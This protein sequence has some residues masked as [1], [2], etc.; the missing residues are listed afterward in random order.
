[1]LSFSAASPAAEGRFQHPNLTP[2]VL[3]LEK[4][5]EQKNFPSKPPSS[6]NP[7]SH[8]QGAEG[9]LYLFFSILGSLRFLLTLPRNRT[10]VPH[11]SSAT[12]GRYVGE[13]SCLVPWVPS[14]LHG[15]ELPGTIRLLSA[16]KG[17]RTLRASYEP[18][19]TQWPGDCSINGRLGSIAEG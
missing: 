19:R 18:A 9:S 5:P 4:L 1:V 12:G 3:I 11:R 6:S 8:G 13:E 10:R 2:R 16:R 15:S 17:A 14:S 7:R